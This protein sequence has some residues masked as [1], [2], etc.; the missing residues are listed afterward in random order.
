MI[1]SAQI[2]INPTTP[3]LIAQASIGSLFTLV[4][5]GA[6]NVL[7][8]GTTAVL[9]NSASVTQTTGFSIQLFSPFGGQQ[10]QFYDII[11]SNGDQLYAL[12]GGT[13]RT[14]NVLIVE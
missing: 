2:A 4:R 1:T 12:D 14:I 10:P 7:S 8:G 13:S 3:V 11:L 5:L 9:G 6:G